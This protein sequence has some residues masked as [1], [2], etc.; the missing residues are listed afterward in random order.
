MAFSK[1]NLDYPSTTFVAF[2][3]KLLSGTS[4]LKKFAAAL[5]MQD[6][7]FHL[8]CNSWIKLFQWYKQKPVDFLFALRQTSDSYSIW[9]EFNL[10]ILFENLQERDRVILVEGLHGK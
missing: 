5:D 2:Q 3:T 6:Y 9:A 4:V 7:L 8:K 1:G 10:R